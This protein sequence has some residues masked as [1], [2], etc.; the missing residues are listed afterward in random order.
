[1]LT[2]TCSAPRPHNHQG[3]GWSE[4]WDSG[5]SDLW[6]RGEPSRALVN[7]IESKPD[8]IP[9]PSRSSRRPRAL[10]PGC[11]KGYDVAMLALHGYDVYGL[12]VSPTAVET[13]RAYAATQFAAPS[14]YNFLNASTEDQYLGSERGQVRFIVD[15][16]FA[17]GWE[18]ECRSNDEEF[19]GFDLIYDY[20]F[21]CALFPEMRQ[22]WAQ[23]MSELISPSGVLVCLE[24]P[25]YKD[26]K[27]P[28][29]PWGL[30]EGIYWDLLVAGGNGIFDDEETAKTATQAASGGAFKRLQYIKPPRSYKVAKGTDMLSIWAL[31]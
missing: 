20:T 23:R 15:D 21:L 22:D 6:D 26:L 17:R 16:F 5:Q 29:P 13:A 30:R 12:E 10:V 27:L 14:P 28:G 11:G 3:I 19:T 25:S 24:F 8:L 7:L 18:V 9:H 31:R 1:M 4:L 2:S